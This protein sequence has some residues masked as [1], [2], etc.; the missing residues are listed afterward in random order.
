MREPSEETNASKTD[1]IRDN[2][3]DETPAEKMNTYT[4]FRNWRL[5]PTTGKIKVKPNAITKLW[6]EVT[7]ED[8]P[9]YNE[10][11]WL[12]KLT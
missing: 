2:S 8:M 3:P 5:Q 7:K 4:D 12:Y 11:D 6:K 10:E 9:E 1:E